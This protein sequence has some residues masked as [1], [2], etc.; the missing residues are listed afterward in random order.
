MVG[1]EMNYVTEQ[2]NKS[3]TQRTRRCM[4][5]E[6]APAVGFPSHH[7]FVVQKELSKRLREGRTA[8]KD[9]RFGKTVQDK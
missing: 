7:F 9:A 5:V 8:I 6:V 4:A 2:A 3:V 1:K